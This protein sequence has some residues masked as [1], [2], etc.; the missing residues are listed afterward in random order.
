MVEHEHVYAPGVAA[1]IQFPIIRTTL[2]RLRGVAQV[3]YNNELD[4]KE[5]FQIIADL[6]LWQSVA[7]IL[8]LYINAKRLSPNLQQI[9]MYGNKCKSNYGPLL[10][11]IFGDRFRPSDE[12]DTD[13]QS[14]F[15]IIFN[16]GFDIARQFPDLGQADLTLL[17]PEV[18]SAGFV[19]NYSLFYNLLD[20]VIVGVEILIFYD[21][22]GRSSYFA[23]FPQIHWQVNVETIVQVG[24]GIVFSPI[25]VVPV[26][27]HR[28][29]FENF[30]DSDR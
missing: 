10:V 5:A 20:D 3:T 14:G 30:L 27:A 6:Y 28:L 19:L 11:P 9:V 7:A 15:N 26:F 8:G 24:P 29:I 13:D 25:K 16:P 21:V 1:E 17:E 23:V 18:G 4:Y 12:S 22:R 2:Q